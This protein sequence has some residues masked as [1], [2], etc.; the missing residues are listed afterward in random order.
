[1]TI[2]V[3]RTLAKK[4]LCFVAGIT[5]IREYRIMASPGENINMVQKDLHFNPYSLVCNVKRTMTKDQKDEV[6]QDEC[7][8]ST[9]HGCLFFTVRLIRW[10]VAID[11]EFGLDWIALQFRA[12]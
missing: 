11:Q 2:Q 1:V 5:V 7:R 4:S 3:E 12:S 9:K 6:K 10:S 8:Y